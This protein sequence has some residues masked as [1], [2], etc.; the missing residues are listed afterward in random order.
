VKPARSVALGALTLVLV[1]IATSS[2]AAAAEK[3]ECYLHP[4]VQR[5]CV[6]TANL[7]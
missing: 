5:R 3:Q 6:Q 1:L 4:E 7:N 2:A